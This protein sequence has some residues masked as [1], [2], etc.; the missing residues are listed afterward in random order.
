MQNQSD[1]ISLGH[2]DSEPEDPDHV[3]FPD[4]VKK[5]PTTSAAKAMIPKLDLTK[6]KQIQDFNA[7]KSTLEQQQ[8]A[9]PVDPKL[10]EKVTQ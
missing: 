10:K 4:K 3:L 5:K 6:A 1:A 8:A 2:G 7:K 9:A